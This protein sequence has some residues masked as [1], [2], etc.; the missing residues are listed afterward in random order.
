MKMPVLVGV[1]ECNRRR[2]RIEACELRRT[3]NIVD[4]EL[5]VSALDRRFFFQAEDGIRDYKVTG[6]QTCALPIS[7]NHEDA[8]ELLV[9][10]IL[11]AQCTDARVNVISPALFQRWP[12]ATSMATASQAEMEDRKSVV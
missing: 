12:D 3:G 6:V 5:E 1:R 7:L 11:A 2:R 8:F 10:T 9:A 4:M